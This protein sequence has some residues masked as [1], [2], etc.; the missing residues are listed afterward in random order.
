[1]HLGD[2][3]PHGG[4]CL[5]VALAEQLVR[6]FGEFL[7]FAV[8][9]RAVVRVCGVDISPRSVPHELP[10]GSV[11]CSNDRTLALLMS[12]LGANLGA[13]VGRHRATLGHIGPGPGR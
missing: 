7:G 10:A 13:N 1:M 5:P 11:F 6:L 8:M 12:W 3:G 9:L 4:S 2:G